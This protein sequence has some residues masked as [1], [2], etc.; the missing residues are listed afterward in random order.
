MSD[1]VELSV[2]GRVVRARR[3]S[4][5]ASALLS[6]DE[7]AFRSSPTGQVRAP[8]CG[9]GICFECRVTVDGVPHQ[10]ACLTLVREQMRIATGDRA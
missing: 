4:T 1:T 3:G 9:M 10:R 8:L 2:N 6:A 5:V 7:T